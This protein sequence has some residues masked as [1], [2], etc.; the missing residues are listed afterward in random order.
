VSS[1]ASFPDATVGNIATTA[2]AADIRLSQQQ[3]QQQQQ[4]QH[5]AF[6]FK[7]GG[8]ANKGSSR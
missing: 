5:R 4:Q 7:P 3:Q 6:A 2:S 8:M 1:K